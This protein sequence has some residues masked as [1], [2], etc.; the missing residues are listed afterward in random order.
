MFGFAGCERK[1]SAPGN[2]AE[3]START[4]LEQ[5][6]SAWQQGD[7]AA[8][9]SRFT[10]IDWSRG[11]A[12]SKNAA[13]SLREKDLATLTP[14][15][16]QRRMEEVM[17]QLKELKP[18]FS[19]VAQAGKDAAAKKDYAEARRC[20]TKLNQCGE[21]LDTPDGLLIVKL[22]GRA[23]KKMAAKE[24]ALLP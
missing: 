10:E 11:A 5:A 12:F 19:A 20:F 1:G 6:I 13:S 24:S 14:A 8:A 17:A 16:R 9:V 7:R 22:V 3:P 2:Q 4:P 23:A 18:L 21:A 15:D